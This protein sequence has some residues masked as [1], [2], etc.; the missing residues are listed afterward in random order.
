VKT[1]KKERENM[2][3]SV[4]KKDQFRRALSKKHKENKEDNKD[5]ISMKA[6]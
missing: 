6:E 4:I 3:Q 2:D 5:L 1:T